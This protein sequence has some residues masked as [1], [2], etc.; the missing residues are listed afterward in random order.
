MALMHF[1]ETEQKT[2]FDSFQ[3]SKDTWFT[4][5]I[6]KQGNQINMYYNGE[7]KSTYTETDNSASQL[8]AVDAVSP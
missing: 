6:E 2:T 7:I 4:L 5:A 8:I 1:I 3:E